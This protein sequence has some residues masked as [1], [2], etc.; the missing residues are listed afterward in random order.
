M[1]NTKFFWGARLGKKLKT[2]DNYMKLGKFKLHPSLSFFLPPSQWY[3]QDNS[4]KP[5]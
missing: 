1:Q 5:K 2:E 3:K 4:L